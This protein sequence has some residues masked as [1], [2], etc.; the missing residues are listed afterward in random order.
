MKV[1]TEMLKSLVIFFAISYGLLCG[2]Y[3]YCSI[4]ILAPL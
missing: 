1:T 3:G 4:I 2:G